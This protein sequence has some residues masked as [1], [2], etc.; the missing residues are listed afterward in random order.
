MAKIDES[1]TFE[2]N[3]SKILTGL[4]KEGV[5]CPAFLLT[6]KGRKKAVDIC[7]NSELW[8]TFIDQRL[9]W[10]S[11]LWDTIECSDTK[12]NQYNF[13]AMTSKAVYNNFLHTMRN[14]HLA[15]SYD[16]FSGVCALFMER[17]VT[18]IF[19]LP[20][21]LKKE[22]T[23]IEARD[24]VEKIEGVRKKVHKKA[25]KKSKKKKKS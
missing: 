24:L 5:T 18:D 17:V 20:Q 11:K 7:E 8:T 3:I 22:M 21:E 16:E 19:G 15:I 2:K 10:A 23:D 13:A 25:R 12:Q 1:I 14:Y 9:E 6:E 4:E